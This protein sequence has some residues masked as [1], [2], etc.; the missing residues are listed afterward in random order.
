MNSRW[1]C[2]GVSF[3]G[4][5]V[6]LS[7]VAKTLGESGMTVRDFV[8]EK[9]WGQLPAMEQVRSQQALSRCVYTGEDQAIE[10]ES[11][12]ANGKQRWRT[13]FI[14]CVRPA[15]V[16]SITE[17]LLEFP[18]VTENEKLTLSCLIQGF[19]VREM[20]DAFQVSE[21]AINQ[22]LSRL[23]AKFNAKTNARL[24]VLAWQAGVR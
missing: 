23:R 18:E 17:L 11:D 22:R 21:E 10:L 7:G 3:D 24:A 19:D 1:F 15:E 8:G 16:M 14:K 9:I 13:R 6:A 5:I 12:I 2:L 20:A 4:A